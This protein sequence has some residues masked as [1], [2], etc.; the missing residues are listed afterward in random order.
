MNILHADAVLGGFKQKREEMVMPVIASILI[1]SYVGTAGLRP[2]LLYDKQFVKRS[3][4]FWVSRMKNTR[5]VSNVSDRDIEVG[6][7][8]KLQGGTETSRRFKFS[9]M[10]TS[11]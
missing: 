3:V 9:A 10:P 11:L 2:L 1:L 6:F 4:K 5:L 8:Q 7:A